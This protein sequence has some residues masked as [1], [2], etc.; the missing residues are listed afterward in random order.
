MTEE[1]HELRNGMWVRD[2]RT[3]RI[4]EFD[5]RSRAYPVTE[6]AGEEIH[7][8]TWRLT[9]DFVIDQGAEGAC[10]GFAMANMMMAAP[11]EHRFGKEPETERV[12]REGIYWRAQQIDQWPGGSYPGANPFY[13][14]TSILAGLKVLKEMGF[15]SGYRWSF[16]L[17]DLVRGLV[18]VGPAVLG[19]PW[20]MDCYTPDADGRIR[21]TGAWIGGH[22]IV[23]RGVRL[24]WSNYNGRFSGL[25]LER[26][27]VILRNSWGPK[28]G[29]LW[30]DC[31]V[32]LRDLDEWLPLGGE[33]AFVTSDG[34][35]ESL[36][37][38]VETDTPAGLPLV[39]ALRGY[40]EL[41]AE[42]DER[43]REGL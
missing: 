9:R 36:S 22:A 18:H 38:S 21:P 8:W 17:A 33:A 12:A 32:S 1:M 13:E 7:S 3:D 43:L 42:R 16:S 24:R 23:A 29:P 40:E 30:G 39:E 37:T 28:W 35:R 10:V 34:A 14:G 2:K 11:Y 6:V 20:F 19:L 5:E 31:L 26:S 15:I 4:I 41:D 27:E 25:N